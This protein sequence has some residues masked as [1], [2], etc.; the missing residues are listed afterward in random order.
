MQ[1]QEE[2]QLAYDN[3]EFHLIY[4]KVHNFCAVDLGSFYLDVIKDR[5]YT[6]QTDSV[7]RRSAQSAVYHIA[8][9]MVR[10]FAPILSFTAEE[11]WQYLP[12]ERSKSVLFAEWYEFPEVHKDPYGMDLDYWARMMEVRDCVNKELERLRVAGEIGANLEAEVG[13]YCGRE[14]YDMLQRL[15]D[16]LRFVLITSAARIYLAGEPPK[17]AQHCILSSN[18]ELWISV[19]ASA[20]TKCVRCW[21]YRGDVGSNPEHPE[22][23]G[24]CVAN[25]AGAGETRQFA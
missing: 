4:Q 19:S 15:G 7:A 17:E 25:V 10:W 18:D 9:A 22:L 11:I 2:L 5:Q 6:T 13:L 12:G 16:E 14:I 3:Y 8:E 24:R 1:L 21:H 23:C 20:H